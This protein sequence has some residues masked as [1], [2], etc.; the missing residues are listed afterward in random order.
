LA[1]QLLQRLLFII[2]AILYWLLD[3]EPSRSGSIKLVRAISN[4]GTSSATAT[5]SCELKTIIENEI[6][7]FASCS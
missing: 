5:T 3:S 1:S 7:I 6:G 4:F 2:H